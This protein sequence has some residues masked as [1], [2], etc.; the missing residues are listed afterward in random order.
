M[1]GLQHLQ[2]LCLP[3]LIY[4][5]ICL[6]TWTGLFQ[7]VLGSGRNSCSGVTNMGVPMPSSRPGRCSLTVPGASTVEDLLKTTDSDI[8]N[9]T[10]TAKYLEE[11]LLCRISHPFT[12][13]HLAEVLV[14]IHIPTRKN[15]WPSHRS[16]QGVVYLLQEQV[17]SKI[18]TLILNHIK[19]NVAKEV[20]NHIITAISLHVA[21]I[22]D[23]LS[24]F[25]TMS[26]SQTT[27]RTHYPTSYYHQHWK[28]Q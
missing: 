17:A 10:N 22:H 16:N 6:L 20:S 4:I 2:P 7:M 14:H 21:N 27:H 23:Q 5:P 24:P 3:L 11:K 19:T 12:T 28:R 25:T 1:P 15:T 8:S 9:A 13:S 26:T 18:A